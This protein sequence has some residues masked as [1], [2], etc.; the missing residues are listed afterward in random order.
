MGRH[1][2]HGHAPPSPL[3]DA[4]A[5]VG[6]RWTL[7]VVAALL[8]GEKRFNELQEELDGIAP[9][10]LSGRLKALV[11]QALVVSR[12]YSERPPRF[13]YELTESGR[14]LAG[15]LRLLADWGARTAGDA[16]PLRHAVCGTAVEARWW[17]PDCE[18]VVDD[19]AD[20]VVHV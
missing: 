9:N 10:V 5:R 20:D 2:R 13:V 18:Q 12:P 14:E 3:A 16:E 8:E 6:D 7:L 15:A 17:C 19:A 4:L 1:R 11:E